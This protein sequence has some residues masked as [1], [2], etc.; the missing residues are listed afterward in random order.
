[1]IY[2]VLKVLTMVNVKNMVL[3]VVKLC[4]MKTSRRFG[5]TYHLHRQDQIV[6]QAAAGDD[7]LGFIKS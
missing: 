2:V 5:G 3:W 6:S 1:M 4:R 7:K